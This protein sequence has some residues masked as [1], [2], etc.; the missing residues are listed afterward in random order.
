MNVPDLVALDGSDMQRLVDG[1]DAALNDLM[2]RHSEKLFHYLAR[3]LQNE[4]EAADVAQETFVRVYK[5]RAHFKA[6]QKFS[7]WL[8]TIATNLARDRFKW[9]SR[10]PEVSL[11]SPVPGTDHEMGSLLA[12]DRPAPDAELLGDERSRAIAAA[13]AALPTDMRAPLILSEYEDLPNAEIA[14]VLGASV[15][16]IESRLHRARQ[17]L[18]AD[19]A[20]WVTKS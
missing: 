2:A 3:Q 16:A 19:L 13:V 20:P 15:K 11:H 9:R 1:H 14:Q 6:G 17:Q 5:Y 18:R 10:H 12:D 4:T 8:Y 7:T